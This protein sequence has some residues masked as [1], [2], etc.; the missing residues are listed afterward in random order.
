MK[1]TVTRPLVFFDLETTGIDVYRD[2]IVQIGAIK[3]M[4]DGTQTEH[5][6][7]VNP[8]MP[9]PKG[10]SDI[11]G[12]TDEIVADAP[13]L[14]DIAAEIATLFND[15][16]LGGY[17]IRNFDIPLLRAEAG[18]IGLEINFE[19]AKVIDGMSIFKIQEPRTLTAAYK[20]FCGEELVD[21]HD[22]IADIRATLAVVEGQLDHYDDLPKAVDDL[23]EFCFPA[24]P[25]ALD[26]EGKIIFVDG[27]LTI[28]FGKNR[29]KSLQSLSM[30]DPGYLEWILK[31]SFSDKV[32]EAVRGVLK[33]SK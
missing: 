30:E 17:N 16:D 28:N 24:N 3:I 19:D 6:W 33:G 18:R 9:I 20:K 29:G 4:P 7:K 1:L 15:A 32:K 10:A 25:D 31:G 11:H 21:A 2:R 12:I 22:A 13:T 8:Q 5:E 14:G 27:E 23:H 26:A